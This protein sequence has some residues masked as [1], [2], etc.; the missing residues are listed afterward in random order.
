ME[1]GATGS[2]RSQSEMGSKR[3]WQKKLG[4]GEGGV[5]SVCGGKKKGAGKE[6]GRGGVSGEALRQKSRG[7]VG[8]K[9]SVTRPTNEI[10]EPIYSKKKRPGEPLREPDN[11][12]SRSRP[13][14][15]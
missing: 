14:P 5:I 8:E 1:G 9:T 2:T 13:A 4:A 10:W 3:N 15:P 6:G 7:V 12:S 11:R